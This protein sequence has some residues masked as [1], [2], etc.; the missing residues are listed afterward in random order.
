MTAPPWSF[1]ADYVESCNCDFGCPCNFNGFP[2]HGSC[3]ALDLFAIRT[4]R[5]GDVP[6]DGL[7]IISA[8]YWPKAIHEGN[9][10][11]QLYVA[12]G[13]NAQQREAIF[14]IFSGRAKGSGPFAQRRSST[15][16]SRSS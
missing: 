8:L 1:T 13:A 15:R 5:Y 6:L 4:G 16:W 14:Q 11:A 9:G 10:T 2:T 3:H 12:E 7:D